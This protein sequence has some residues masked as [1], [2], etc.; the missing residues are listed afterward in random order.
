MATS[1]QSRFMQL[2]FESEIAEALD[3]LQSSLD[4]PDGFEQVVDCV[5]A[6]QDL[7][8]SS[9]SALRPLLECLEDDEAAVVLRALRVVNALIQK[10]PDKA[11]AFRIKNELSGLQYANK[12]EQLSYGADPAVLNE[13]EHFQR[14]LKNDKDESIVERS[15]CCEDACVMTSP[16]SLW[17]LISNLYT[18][19]LDDRTC[20]KR[21]VLLEKFV[22]TLHGIKTEDEAD[23]VLRALQFGITGKESAPQPPTRNSVP[24]P[25]PPPPSLSGPPKNES[26]KVMMPAAPPPPPTSV[27]KGAVS[28]SPPDPGPP[29][30]PP[31]AAL[32]FS[33]KENIELPQSMK[34][35]RSPSKTLKMKTI[36]WSKI[37]PTLVVQ[38]QGS[39]S[40]WGELARENAT[41]SLDFDMIDGMFSIAP[42]HESTTQNQSSVVHSK[43]SLLVDLLTPKR[44]QNVT[45]V[46]KQF[47]DLDLIISDLIANKIGRFDI[48]LLRTLKMILPEAEEVDALRRYTGEVAQLTPA[49]SFFL[50]LIDIPN[51]RLRIECMLLRLEFHRVMEDVVPNLHLLKVACTELRQSSA[52]RHLL[53]LLVNIG[54]Y[55]NSSSSHGNAAG[56]KMSSLWKIIDHKAAKGS[57]SLLHLVAKQDP[58]LL[59]GLESDLQSITK[60]SEISV[61]EIK[62]NLRTL[63]EQCSSLGRQLATNNSGEFAEMRDYLEDHCRIELEE[64]NRSLND[65]FV[66][67]KDVATFFCEDGSSFKIEECLKIFKMIIIRLRQA[68]QENEER[69]ERR[70]RMKGG[71]LHAE[72]NISSKE[73]VTRQDEAFFATLETKQSK[74][75]RRRV[76]DELTRGGEAARTVRV[77]KFKESRINGNVDD[78]RDRTKVMDKE[79]KEHHKEKHIKIRQ[80]APLLP[81]EVSD[82]NDYVETIEKHSSPQHGRNTTLTKTL[83]EPQKHDIMRRKENGDG[84]HLTVPTKRPE[85]LPTKKVD[86]EVASKG[87]E[88]LQ[89]N[90]KFSKN[91]KSGSLAQPVQVEKPFVK[92]KAIAKSTNVTVQKLGNSVFPRFSSL[93]ATKTKAISAERPL[94][95]QT[96]KI[97]PITDRKPAVAVH[98]SHP[99]KETPNSKLKPP[100]HI[101]SITKAR[102]S[103]GTS[104]HGTVAPTRTNTMLPKKV[105]LPPSSTA[106]NRRMSSP[107]TTISEKHQNNTRRLSQ[108]SPKRREEEQSQNVPSKPHVSTSSRPS[109]IKTGSINQKQSL[110]NLDTAEVP[111][112]LRRTIDS[113]SRE[114]TASTTSKPKWV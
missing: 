57:S 39:Q 85:S 6:W 112:P 90:A 31:P 14:L 56:F 48:E 70:S 18:L 46:L 79:N 93:Q 28:P 16:D 58:D 2:I 71:V 15:V 61:E 42:T 91:V 86:E 114:M 74:Q 5:A 33:T 110:P 100:A 78:E 12:L 76:T 96:N 51:Y 21:K 4:E 72:E 23:L 63:D 29:P 94:T 49:C 83:M 7:I 95:A 43:K 98:I 84:K 92:N 104:S 69:V 107:P 36:M 109:L 24:L 68:L 80:T 88:N 44:S 20:K 19:I 11:R 1:I 65:F 17:P 26:P 34:P 64:T 108:A 89:V 54:N 111:K 60:A 62:T 75:S 66:M 99:V 45:I 47:K 35:K 77:R 22:D 82:L 55:L 59:G 105:T 38:G 53:L 3:L 50:R 106:P 10:A 9:D 87:K 113:H 73:E 25:P 40:I 30:P 37:S 67:Q 27:M 81:V 101:S 97:L 52:L 102:A 13:I 32:G 41:L 103:A 8:D